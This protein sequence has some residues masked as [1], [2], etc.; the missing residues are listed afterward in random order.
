MTPL[1]LMLVCGMF[2][3]STLKEGCA[4]AAALSLTF[5]CRFHINTARKTAQTDIPPR[6]PPTMAPVLA[7]VVSEA[8]DEVG[9][10]ASILVVCVSVVEVSVDV[11]TAKKDVGGTLVESHQAL[12][13]VVLR[14]SRKYCQLQI[15]AVASVLQ[16]VRC[17]S[18]KGATSL[19]MCLP[20]SR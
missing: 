8:E 9:I 7:D 12:E 16:T 17:S 10:P 1:A 19:P 14:E 11:A 4:G 6:T 18:Q 20:R 2:E 5:R 13:Y 3:P 15:P